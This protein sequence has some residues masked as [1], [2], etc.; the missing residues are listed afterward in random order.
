M[1]R[2]SG[3]RMQEINDGDRLQNGVAHVIPGGK[4]AFFKGNRHV[5]WC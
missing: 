1:S 4:H 5:T 2:K 3:L